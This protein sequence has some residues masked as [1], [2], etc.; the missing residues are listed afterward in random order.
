MSVVVQISGKSLYE[1]MT[2]VWPSYSYMTNRVGWNGTGFPGGEW[3]IPRMARCNRTSMIG[4]LPPVMNLSLMMSTSMH[5]IIF[6]AVDIVHLRG[7]KG[8]AWC[9][10]EKM[11]VWLCITICTYP[12]GDSKRG[13]PRSLVQMSSE[14]PFAVVLSSKTML[15]LSGGFVD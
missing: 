10:T 5:G 9:M 2:G 7:G 3:C 13:W 14:V 8:A 4:M 1:A 15:P 11:N 12:L 6:L